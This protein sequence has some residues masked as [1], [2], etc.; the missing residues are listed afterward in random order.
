MI[1]HNSILDASNGIKIEKGCQIGA[2]VG[3]FSHSSHNA[4][5]LMGE[6]YLKT[7]IVDRV[8][9]VH[10]RVEIG[11]YVFVGTSSLIYP[12]TRIGKGS[13]VLSGS[14]VKGEIPNY[15][16]ISGN[17]AKV[18]TTIDNI[19]RLYLKNKNVQ[20]NYFDQNLLEKMLKKYKIKKYE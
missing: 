14:H 9:Y 1:W 12:G 17:P 6:N 5:R 11:E 7:E 4:I 13:I 3:I 15:S 8:G 20:K 19:D 2:F 16:I 10:G 18:I